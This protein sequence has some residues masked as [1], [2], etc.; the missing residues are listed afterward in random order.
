MDN[1]RIIGTI[2]TLMEEINKMSQSYP[3]ESRYIFE[4]LTQR[5][6]ITPD[7]I[8]LALEGRI[9][10]QRG[11]VVMRTLMM[12]KNALFEL[13]GKKLY[14]SVPVRYVPKGPPEVN[15]NDPNYNVRYGYEQLR[16]KENKKDKKEKEMAKRVAGFWR[17]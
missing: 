3:N 16:L 17:Q 8:K 4:T 1:S 2:R 12:I 9:E 11:P 15:S 14:D 6:A 10:R 13:Q 5:E 7:E